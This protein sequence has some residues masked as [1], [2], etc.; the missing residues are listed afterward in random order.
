[1]IEASAINPKIRVISYGPSHERIS[2]DGIVYGAAGIT[3]K[4][5]GFFHEV[6]ELMGDSEDPAKI[7]ETSA[8][9]NDS[10]IKSAGAGHASMATT[11]GLWFSMEGNCSKLVDSVFTTARYGSALMPSGRRIP[12]SKENIVVPAGIHSDSEMRKIYTKTMENN[13]AAYEELQAR[14]VP[15]EEAAKIVP[16]GHKG[17]GVMFM[18]LET[19]VYFSRESERVGDLMP[20]EGRQIIRE[21][22]NFVKENGMEAVYEAR[23]SA[24]RTTGINP[25]VF[26][27]D[28]N[29]A[30]ELIIQGNGL[31]PLLLDVSVLPSKKRD[32]RIESYLA[33]RAEVFAQPEKIAG[34]WQGLLAELGSIVADFNDSVTVKTAVNTPWRVWGEVKR[35]RTLP[36]T[37]E[38]VYHAVERATTL[39]LDA[40]LPML[41]NFFSVPS[42]V[43]GDSGNLRIWRGRWIES[44]MAYKNLLA[45]GASKS[46]AIALVPR[47]LKLGVVKNF[48][49]Y[50]LTT[51]YMSLRL[52]STAEKEMRQI[53]E[54]ERDLIKSDNRVPSNIAALLAPKCNYTGFCPD[55]KFCG[56]VSSVVPQYDI[57]FHKK[58]AKLR[59]EE[60]REK[61]TS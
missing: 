52:C 1:M 3:Y 10:L 46:D 8:K 47:G 11:P 15:K 25:S 6:L 4:D 19:L 51:G 2:A 44:L 17:G 56:N 36:Q 35:H 9:I 58:I 32:K 31:A 45:N 37:A 59:A 43:A 49:L 53:T 18:P 48:D 13:I 23:K 12:I 38:S 54:A 21:L 40:E 34:N 50:N 27:E 42:S 28:G 29:L 55:A 20:R 57:D 24:P 30:H 39:P 16:Y 7:K 33:R 14:G 41:A 26:H 60:I 5:V 22:E 61:L